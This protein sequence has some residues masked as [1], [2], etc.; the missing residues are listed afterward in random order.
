MGDPSDQ[1]GIVNRIF[2][3]TQ[4]QFDYAIELLAAYRHATEVERRGAVLWHGEMIDEAN[5][6]MAVAI[7]AAGR[8][9]GLTQTTDGA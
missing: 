5:R 9:A 8:A 1:I 6:K 7:E 3:P 4:E 2:S